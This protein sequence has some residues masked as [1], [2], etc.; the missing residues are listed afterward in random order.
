MLN[1]VYHIPDT[2]LDVCIAL[3]SGIAALFIP[4]FYTVVIR[5]DEK[6]ES[7]LI[8]RFFWAEKVV[9]RF[10]I[11]TLVLL[12]LT[13]IYSLKLQPWILTEN[14]FICNSAVFLTG[15][16]LVLTVVL[17]IL[18]LIKLNQYQDP[19]KL[20]HLI[21]YSKSFA[22]KERRIVRFDLLFHSLKD[23][24]YNKD[25]TKTICDE[26]E[27]EILGYKDK[28][29]NLPIEYFDALEQLSA[30]VFDSNFNNDY[31][32]NRFIVFRLW[33]DVFFYRFPLDELTYTLLWYH[34]SQAV[35]YDRDK[36]LLKHWERAHSLVKMR[37]FISSDIEFYDL[38]QEE[39]KSILKDH[40]KFI[41]FHVVFTS[42]LL[43]SNKIDVLKNC[44]EYTSSWPPDYHLLP[45]GSHKIIE[46]F[47][48]F[49]DPFDSNNLWFSWKYSF[50]GSSGFEQDGRIKKS[51]NQYLILLLFRSKAHISDKE[52]FNY[53]DLNKN[54][55][56]EY[57]RALD[58]LCN[59]IQ[60]LPDLNLFNRIIQPEI[61]DSQKVKLLGKIKDLKNKIISHRAQRKS[62]ENM[63]PSKIE[64][65][66]LIIQEKLNPFMTELLKL[67]VA[68]NDSL[69]DSYSGFKSTV[70][71]DFFLAE[72][73]VTYFDYEKTFASAFEQ[74]LKHRLG[75]ALEQ[76]VAQRY[77][78]KAESIKSTVESLNKTVLIL[79][80]GVNAIKS[81]SRP[82]IINLDLVTGVTPRTYLISPEN[83]S[84][85]GLLFNEFELNENY[86]IKK[87]FT[88]NNIEIGIGK[89]IQ[90]NLKD[91]F[92]TL[93]YDD[94]DLENTIGIDISTSISFVIPE[95]LK[96]ICLIEHQPYRESKSPDSIT[97][98]Q[99]KQVLGKKSI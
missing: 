48:Y 30:V 2:F 63:N 53:R 52:I 31:R 45:K 54:Q 28:A 7:R 80:F 90:G 18:S 57:E 96:C 66:C 68:S 71:K 64:S 50:P 93:V 55:C 81:L 22:K 94:M 84:S 67:K 4:L 51:I 89:L 78:I 75:Y 41:R 98:D 86:E 56:N 42:L 27:N 10:L 40:D 33:G 60:N 23:L 44:L 37:G 73:E 21:N 26:L 70:D 95:S 3:T 97:I 25:F 35:E 5:L 15:L 17:G 14:V 16:C 61:D 11:S 85:F 62:Q 58:A 72:S 88:D 1:T 38:P 74:N 65:F 9:K 6:Y 91:L 43:H 47:Q 77:T 12:V 83:L 13:V 19:E 39:Q 79:N 87:S 82:N 29:E 99:I 92:T 24:N 36:L 76:K 49:N 34:L 20:F 59:E 32:Q 46:L 8:I 69:N